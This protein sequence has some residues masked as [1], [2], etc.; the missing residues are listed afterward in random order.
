[1]TI[2]Y[3]GR[4][5]VV[6]GAGAGLG[7][8]HALFLAARG[9]KVVVNDL[10]GTVEGKGGSHAA[11]DQVVA[12]IRAAGGTAVPNYDSVA[13]EAGARR[14]V[15]TA[16]DEFGRVDILVNNAGNNRESSFRKMTMEDFRSVIDVHL[17]GAVY[18]TQAVWQGMLDRQYGRVVMTASAAGL[19]GGHGLSNYAAAKIAVVGLMHSLYLEGASKN[20]TVN[21]IA[22]MATTRMSKDAMDDKTGPL[23]KPEFVTAMVGLLCA[24]SHTGSGEIF[25]CGAGYYSKIAVVEGFG[26]ILGAAAPPTPETLAERLADIRDLSQAKP[27]KDAFASVAETMRRVLRNANAG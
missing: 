15:A 2:N 25:S 5:A 13:D 9:A 4:V 27:Y 26:V 17:M 23:L 1:M 12:E 7:R 3:N 10:G 6:T 11:A 19:F 20:V 22:P 21:A 8:S 16:V 14:I 24:E 18:C